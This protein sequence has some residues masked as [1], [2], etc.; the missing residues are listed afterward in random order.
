MFDLDDK[1]QVFCMFLSFH[2]KEK[3]ETLFPKFIYKVKE[4]K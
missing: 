4:K 1:F 3:W 2:D